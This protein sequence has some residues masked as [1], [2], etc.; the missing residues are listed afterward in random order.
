[1]AEQRTTLDVQLQVALV[2]QFQSTAQGDSRVVR[3]EGAVDESFFEGPDGNSVEEGCGGR[4]RTAGLPYGGGVEEVGVVAAR[5]AVV[6]QADS[7][8]S[9]FT[10]SADEADRPKVSA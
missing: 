2:A 3:A 9:L 8:A 10:R 7:V 5:G 4:G 1:M 6:G